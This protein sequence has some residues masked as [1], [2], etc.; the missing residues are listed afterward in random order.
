MYYMYMYMYMCYMYYIGNRGIDTLFIE[1]AMQCAN[2]VYSLHKTSTRDHFIRK[3]KENEWHLE[4]VG[5]SLCLLTYM[6]TC[7]HVYMHTHI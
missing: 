6:H 4:M 3:A 1:K 7:I 2:V 5:R